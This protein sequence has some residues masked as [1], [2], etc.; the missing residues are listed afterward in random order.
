[1]HG[2]DHRRKLQGRSA[3]WSSW[4]LIPQKGEGLDSW[5]KVV[6]TGHVIPNT[7]MWES[8]WPHGWS[9]GEG[10]ASLSMEAVSH[11][12][13]P[14]AA[15]GILLI[16]LLFRNYQSL[17]SM[18]FRAFYTG[19]WNNAVGVRIFTPLKNRSSET[20]SNHL[21]QQ[22]KVMVSPHFMASLP[23]AKTFPVLYG[24]TRYRWCWLILGSFLPQKQGAMQ[25]CCYFTRDW[26]SLR[27][28]SWAKWRSKDS[29][30]EYSKPSC[31]A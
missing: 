15:M 4:K 26:S 10:R 21:K 28:F 22:K 8:A 16:K 30:K 6:T 19:I 13:K 7:C 23:Y 14:T 31:H 9:Q 29:S 27:Q 3:C 5:T 2:R 24:L 11:Q 17:T 1:M 18:H 12:L 25:V 20:S